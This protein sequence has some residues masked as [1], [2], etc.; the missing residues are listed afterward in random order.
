MSEI[1]LIVLSDTGA[2]IYGI[3]SISTYENSFV[4]KLYFERITVHEPHP[5]TPQATLVPVKPSRNYESQLCSA[6]PQ[7]KIYF[8]ES[9]TLVSDIICK[10]LSWIRNLFDHLK[11][12]A[13]YR[14]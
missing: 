10:V 14:L 9:I 4:D 11:N 13:E 5:P 6:I 7:Y 8:G 3:W 1:K 2:T 12:M